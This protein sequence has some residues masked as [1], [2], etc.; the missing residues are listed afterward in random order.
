MNSIGSISSRSSR[1]HVRRLVEAAATAPLWHDDPS[2]AALHGASASILPPRD[3]DVIVVGAGL[4][5]MWTAWWLRQLRPEWSVAVVDTRGAGGGASS[6]NG[7]WCSAVLPVSLG[8]V[9]ASHGASVATELYRESIANVRTI[10]NFVA[11]HGINCDWR[12]GGT[13]V[14]AT[15]ASQVATLQ[16]DVRTW[17]QHGFRDEVR[18]L[19]PASVADVINVARTHGACFQDVCAS[20]HPV[21][22]LEGIVHCVRALGVTIHS[23]VTAHEIGTGAVL[24]DRGTITTRHVVRATEAFTPAFRQYHRDV[25]PIYSLMVA[26]EPLPDDVRRSLTWTDGTT[27]TDGGELVV[28]AQLTADGR[29]AFGG[30]GARTPY[31]SRPLDPTELSRRVH[32]RLV[33]AMHGYFPATADVGITHRWGGAVA[34]HRTWWPAVYVD[35]R[36][37]SPEHTNLAIGGY[38]GDGVATSHLL[39]QRAAHLLADRGAPRHVLLA[40]RPRRWEPEPLRWIGAQLMI[41]LISAID[42][43]EARRHAPSSVLRAVLRRIIGK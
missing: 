36:T 24:T 23:P 3:V 19:E 28:Y 18:W 26:T 8:A 27:F 40:D 10:G 13:L 38:V 29:L 30:R 41:S 33:T 11:Q 43:R 7:G 6:R 35:E 22:L 15:H 9:S 32:E 34:A 2:W 4:S 5:G 17:L 1:G 21:R 25:L 20:L 12:A 39:A 31:A 37:S 42:R 14:N 16:S